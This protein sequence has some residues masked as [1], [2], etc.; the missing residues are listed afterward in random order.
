MKSP[1][2]KYIRSLGKRQLSLT[3]KAKARNTLNSK[4]KI[5]L[6]YAVGGICWLLHVWYV[7]NQ[8]VSISELFWTL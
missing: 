6:N 2:E 1:A 7:F 3:E 5:V 4:I 8:V